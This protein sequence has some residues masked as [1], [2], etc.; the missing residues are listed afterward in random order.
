M[1]T[2]K[3]SRS[4]GVAVSSKAA[5]MPPTPPPSTATL[6]LAP[7]PAPRRSIGPSLSA[8]G[9]SVCVRCA[10]R[11]AR[12][13]NMLGAVN[14][15]DETPAV[16]SKHDLAMVRRGYE[17][18]NDG[19]I[20]GL[21]DTCFTED[22]EWHAAPEW[23]GERL[24]RGREEVGEAE[25]E[26]SLRHRVRDEDPGQHAD[27]RE[28]A[29]ERAVAEPHVAV[30]RLAPRARERDRHDREQGRRL[31]VELA[32]AEEDRERRD[33]QDPAADAEQ[34]A[35][36]AAGETEHRCEH[37]VHSQP[38]RERSA[39]RRPPRARRRRAA[40]RR[41]GAPAAEAPSRRPRRRSSGRRSAPP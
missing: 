32:L 11:F 22:V 13:A 14:G 21:A 33:E 28:R 10:T 34:A 16:V 31:G 8:E 1:V 39:G 3:R 35:H 36:G 23:P 30:A 40:R 27:R 38:L 15:A 24:F 25:L 4:S 17:L 20:R 37:V 41:A 29:H 6:V 5:V 12:L 19:D 7:E 18:W 26:R 2:S 9:A